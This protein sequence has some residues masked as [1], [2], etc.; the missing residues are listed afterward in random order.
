MEVKVSFD[1]EGI[2]S[3]VEARGHAGSEPSGS[4]PAC[5]AATI[6][7]RTAYETLSAISGLE[8]SGEAPSP[9]MLHF[10]VKRYPAGSTQRLLG[11]GD[12]LL[13]GLSGVERE[14]PG[15]IHVIIDGERRK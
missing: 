7:L 13:V 15:K 9:G 14:Y 5:A 1:S 2:I 3:R 4:N 12:F 6:L 11:I 10:V 8:A